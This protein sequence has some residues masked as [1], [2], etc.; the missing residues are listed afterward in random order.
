[1][2]KPENLCEGIP[3]LSYNI[4]SKIVVSGHLVYF[5]LW[6]K[7]RGLTFKVHAFLFGGYPVY[8]D[9]DIW[10]KTIDNSKYKNLKG[11]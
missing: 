5:N 4:K 9:D 6:N 8:W 10:C 11:S 3:Y 7:K 1:L 2:E